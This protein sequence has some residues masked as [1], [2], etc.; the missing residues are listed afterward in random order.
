MSAS[1]SKA[2]I[3]AA[4]EVAAALYRQYGAKRGSHIAAQLLGVSESWAKKIRL[5][6]AEAVSEQV[7]NRAAE[8][9]ASLLRAR[10]A[11]ARRGIA[12]IE[13]MLNGVDLEPTHAHGLSPRGALG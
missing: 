8:A 5:G 10:L 4:R 1:R 6:T 7:A 2:D 11:A 3:S 13:G 12:E 9:R